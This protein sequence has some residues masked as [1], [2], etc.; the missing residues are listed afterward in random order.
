MVNLRRSDLSGRRRRHSRDHE[1]AG[2]DRSLG[3]ILTTVDEV[4][5][6]VAHHDRATVRVGDVFLKIDP[7]QARVGIEIEAMSRAPIPTPQIL[8]REPP[9]LALARVPGSPLGRLGAPSTASSA[10]W[11]AAGR[12]IRALH[13]APPPPWPGR[14]HDEITIELDQECAWLDRSGLLSPDVIACNRTLAASALREWTPAFIHGDLQL[15]HVFVSGDEITGIIDWSEAGPGDAF[16][17][18]ATLTFGHPER[19]GDVVA[20]YGGGVD[21]DVVRG[22]W[23]VRGLRGV[24]WLIEHGFDPDAPGCELDVLRAQA[25]S[26]QG[27]MPRA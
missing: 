18:L 17:D 13:D 4:E 21:V 27:R 26:L 9:A 24:R 25:T 14:T 7:D 12:L 23:S 20:G 22:W 8:W 19:L 3:V 16:Y 10:A 1:S 2:P 11:S 5:V 15:D 6:V